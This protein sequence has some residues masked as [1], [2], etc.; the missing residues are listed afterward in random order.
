MAGRQTVTHCGLQFRVSPD[1]W[2]RRLL[3]FPFYFESTNPSFTVDIK[4]VSEPGPDEYWARDQILFQVVFADGTET[5]KGY[6]VPNLKTGQS[7]R[8]VLKRVYTAYPGQTI[9]RLPLDIGPGRTWETLYSYRVREEEQLYLW[10]F[11]PLA[12]VL[13]SAATTTLSVFIQRWLS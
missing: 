1:F 5:Y 9:I 4:R 3:R 2:L 8:L 10:M 13:F 6:A 12:V 7:S 11:G